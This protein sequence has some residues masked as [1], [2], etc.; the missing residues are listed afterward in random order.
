MVIQQCFHQLM[1][2]STFNP[3][4]QWGS[5]MLEFEGDTNANGEMFSLFGLIED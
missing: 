4:N 1:K 2:W 3:H 5:T